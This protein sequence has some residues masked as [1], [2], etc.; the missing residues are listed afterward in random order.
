LCVVALLLTATT[1]PAQTALS[2]LLVTGKVEAGPPL[3]SQLNIG[4]LPMNIILPPNGNYR[5]VSDMGF[6]RSLASILMPA[7]AAL[8]PMSTIETVTIASTRLPSTPFTIK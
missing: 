3:G 2:N 6:D 8:Y 7:P 4:S 5:L 1:V